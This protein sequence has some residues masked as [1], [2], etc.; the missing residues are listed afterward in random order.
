MSVFVALW[1]GCS[2][3]GSERPSPAGSPSSPP[4]SSPP[5]SSSSAPRD[6]WEQPAIGFDPSFHPYQLGASAEALYLTEYSQGVRVVDDRIDDAFGDAYAASTRASDPTV[7]G[8]DPAGDLWV[9]GSQEIGH[10]DPSGAVL[11]F[12]AL[13][14]WIYAMSATDPAPVV[15]GSLVGDDGVRVA[16]VSELG[17]DGAPEPGFGVAGIAT[18]ALDDGDFE[19]RRVERLSTAEIVVAGSTGIGTPVLAILAPDGALEVVRYGDTTQGVTALAVDDAD[20]ILVASGNQLSRL[21]P[22]ATP[23]PT[24]GTDG[25]VDFPFEFDVNSIWAHGEQIAIIGASED[26]SSQ[27]STAAWALLSDDGSILRREFEPTPAGS[28]MAVAW[29]PDDGAASHTAWV[30]QCEDGDG[31][32]LATRLLRAHVTE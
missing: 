28:I 5:V 6:P 13:D 9:A 22:D 23:D 32:C 24:F 10:Y 8:I 17:S 12:T 29:V 25:A 19:V 21:R 4:S 11:S 15:A 7:V 16:W 18:V 20:R 14:L 26:F 2:S 1:L 31:W 30:A 3:G 27:M